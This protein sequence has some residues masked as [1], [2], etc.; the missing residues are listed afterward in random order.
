MFSEQQRFHEPRLIAPQ[1]E[2]IHDLRNLFGIVASAKH[3]LEREPAPAQRNALLEAIEDAALRGGA[4]TTDLLARARRPFVGAPA[5]LGARLADLSPMMRALAQ[6]P[7]DF[8]LEIGRFDGQARVDGNE[9][10]AAMLELVTNAATAG[11]HRIAVRCRKVGAQIWILVCDDGRG[12]TDAA[13]MQARRGLDAGNDHGAGIARVHRFARAFHGHLRFRSRPDAGTAV[14]LILPAVFSV[15]VDE[16]T[17]PVRSG[18]PMS[19]ETINEQD[20]QPASA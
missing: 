13:L 12:M 19:K 2:A 3:V 6:R 9:F 5:D 11:A 20:R 1:R 15:A 18:I 16:P 4:L 10:D 8:D 7:I 17:T 14:A